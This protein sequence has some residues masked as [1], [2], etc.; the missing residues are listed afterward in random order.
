VSRLLLSVSL[1]LL[2]VALAGLAAANRYQYFSVA[3]PAWSGRTA[4]ETDIRR[5]DRWTGTPQLWTCEDVDT[6]RVASVPPPPDEPA[7][8]SSAGAVDAAAKNG[9]YLIALKAWRTSHPHVNPETMRVTTLRC[10][11]EVAR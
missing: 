4:S 10:H 2:S 6:N 5:I 9:A 8:G 1:I 7:D 11:W 3:G